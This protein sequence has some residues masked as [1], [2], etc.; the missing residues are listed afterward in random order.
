MLKKVN[1]SFEHSYKQKLATRVVN[2]SFEKVTGKICEQKLWTKFW[3]KV[4][5][6]SCE[7]FSCEA[8]LNN[9]KNDWLT[10]GLTGL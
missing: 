5:N 9:L 10:D 8:S 4:L 6:K 2:K 1:K 7:I 3:T